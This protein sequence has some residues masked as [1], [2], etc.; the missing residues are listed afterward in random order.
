MTY[1]VFGG[2]LNPTLPLPEALNGGVYSVKSRLFVLFFYR[3]SELLM[4]LG[5]LQTV[6]VFKSYS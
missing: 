2:T 1:N 6:L 3:A 4:T 5:T